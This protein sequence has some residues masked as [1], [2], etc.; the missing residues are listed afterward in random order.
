MNN[1][2]NNN[3]SQRFADKIRQSTQAKFDAE[4]QAKERE[5]EK[6]R[7]VNDGKISDDEKE[8]RR[9]QQLKENYVKTS[10]DIETGFALIGWKDAVRKTFIHETEHHAFD[11]ACKEFG[12]VEVFKMMEKHDN[13]PFDV[14]A[15]IRGWEN[16]NE[17]VAE[18]EKGQ[19]LITMKAK[20]KLIKI[21]RKGFFSDFDRKEI[22][23]L[24]DANKV[25]E[26]E[27]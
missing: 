14:L 27:K 11:R 5:F 4:N 3:E 22:A 17:Y 15:K 7:I 10:A 21:M 16:W 23:R 2:N 6:F 1:E 18:L 25:P 8:Y 19:Y 26:N 24:L 20:I 13:N 12:G 9:Q